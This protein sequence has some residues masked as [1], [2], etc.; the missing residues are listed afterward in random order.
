MDLATL[1]LK[2]DVTSVL[3]VRHPVTGAP[4]LIDGA[5]VTI[6]LC[7]MDSDRA[8]AA[9]REQVDR[10]LADL[11]GKPVSAA[12]LEQNA[13]TMLAACTV[14]WSANM[15]FDGKPVPCGRAEAI[16]LYEKLPWLREQVD[17]HV[18]SR[19]NFL[20]ASSQG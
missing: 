1:A 3:D 8:K 17:R 5:P 7:G 15:V 11:S 4:L 19:A 20:P 2:G 12:E 18:S 6:T 10:R 14:D 9:R 13:L 16:S